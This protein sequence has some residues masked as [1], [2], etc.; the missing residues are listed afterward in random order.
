MIILTIE[1][2]NKRQRTVDYELPNANYIGYGYNYE[3]QRNSYER[4]NP[5]L[6]YAGYE[7]LYT[8][9]YELTRRNYELQATILLGY[10]SK[11]RPKSVGIDALPT[12]L[13]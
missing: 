4:I 12:E 7:L 6:P 11:T 5:E 1:L 10:M 2:L 8:T 3:S 9:N 13:I